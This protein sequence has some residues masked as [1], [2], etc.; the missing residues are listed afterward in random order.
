MILQRIKAIAKRRE[1]DPGRIGMGE[2]KTGIQR[3]ERNTDF[4][5]SAFPLLFHVRAMELQRRG[6]RR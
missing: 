4:P 3:A 5:G 6:G 1:I 2:L